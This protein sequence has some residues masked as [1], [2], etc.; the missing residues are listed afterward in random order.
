M[1]KVKSLHNLVS[2]EEFGSSGKDGGIGRNTLLPHTTKRR[3]TNLKQ[4][5]QNCQKII[6]WKSNNQ[7]IKEI[8]IQT[9]RRGG[10]GQQ[11][12]VAEHAGNPTF[13]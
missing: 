6:A 1:Y 2:L 8:F 12:K 9:G 13:T 11:G 5:N 10:D 4:N 3:L 7:G